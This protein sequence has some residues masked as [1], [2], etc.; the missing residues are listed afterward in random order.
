VGEFLVFISSK[1]VRKITFKCIVL[2]NKKISLRW[3]FA[4]RVKMRE[5][6]YKHKGFT[7]YR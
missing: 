3:R 2:V 6:I 4:S 1:K 5:N 7:F